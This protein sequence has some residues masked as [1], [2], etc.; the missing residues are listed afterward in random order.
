MRFISQLTIEEKITL[1][2]AHR[3]HPKFF[4]RQRAQ[5]LLWNN[6][7]YTI[8]QVFRL[9]GVK[10]ETMSAWFDRWGSLGIVGLFDEARSGRP[11][12][13]NREERMQFK[14]NVDLNPHQ[15]KEAAAKLQEETG[16]KASFSTFRRILKRELYSWK[17]CRRSLKGQR[18]EELFREAQKELESFREQE[19]EG[20]INMSYFDESGFS[21]IPCIPYAWGPIGKTRLLDSKH[22]K[23]LNILGFM[24]R[25]ND[26]FIYPVEHTVTSLEV[27]AV[28]DSF[29]ANYAT[30]FAETSI[31]HIIILDNASIHHSKVFKS[32]IDYWLKQGVKLYFLPPYSP[33]LNL[34][35]ILWRKVKYEWL[36]LDAYKSYQHMKDT[37][38]DIFANVGSKFSITFE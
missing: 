20:K 34:I 2:E 17:R 13:F 30:K 38:L 32:H 9:L 15:P 14:T 8:T 36:P 27:V 11:P 3:N 35:E 33:E 24:N 37:V 31:P 1:N 28:F 4:V 6:Q 26:V 16:K 12:R 5:A 22:S 29:A 10:R 25:S 23:R 18:D 7:G 19:V 21:T